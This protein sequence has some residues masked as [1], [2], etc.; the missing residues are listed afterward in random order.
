MN[1]SVYR[2]RSTT[3][4]MWVTKLNVYVYI[5]IVP[6]LNQVPQR[7]YIIPQYLVKFWV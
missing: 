7:Q 3:L 5:Y 2:A 1:I 6:V 4:D